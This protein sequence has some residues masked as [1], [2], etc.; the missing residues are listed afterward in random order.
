MTTPDPVD[1]RLL[2]LLAQSG[3]AAVHELAGQLGMDPREAASRLVALSA[4]GLPLIVGA[5]CDQNQLRNILAQLQQ[6]PA[7]S[8][9]APPGYQQQAGV[10]G[11][12]SG[13][14]PA[15]GPQY[16][17]PGAPAGPYPGQ[18]PYP[19]QGAPSGGM[20]A[21]APYPQAANPYAGAVQGT[22]SGQYP[23]PGPPSG[24]TPA[25]P[26]APPAPP[27]P[28]SV[29][30]WGLPQ[31]SAWARGDQPEEAPA[32]PKAGR[33]GETLNTTGLEGQP[34]S[35]HLVEVVDPA[36]FLFTAAGY[37]LGAHERAVVVHT[38]VTNHG[39]RPYN[40]LPDL[41]LM[42]YTAEGH[43]IGKAPISLSSRPPHTIGVPPGE[44]V[45]GHAVYVIG[46]NT[47]I[48]EIRWLARPDST[49]NALTWEL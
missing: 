46:Q 5:E 32:A 1:L 35:I 22:P 36:D 25:A 10:H 33:V 40:T 24:A 26:P 47:R 13:S 4:T 9:Y 41:Y 15:P 16:P 28:E 19:P 14:Y 11:T 2:T 38:E 49:D 42:L 43:A 30:T 18:V 3:R 17:V 27:L 29:S 45:G 21:Q 20:P 39:Q 12:P 31:S 23:P 44:T 37:T 6:P 7:P 8:P 34:I 48:L